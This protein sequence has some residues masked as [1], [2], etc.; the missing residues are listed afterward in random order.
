[1]CSGERVTGRPEKKG[2]EK[3]VRGQEPNVELRKEQTGKLFLGKGGEKIVWPS[4]EGSQTKK[5]HRRKRGLSLMQLPAEKGDW[6]RMTARNRR[7]ERF[8]KKKRKG[9][10]CNGGGHRP[11]FPPNGRRQGKNRVGRWG[12]PVSSL[13]V[14]SGGGGKITKREDLVL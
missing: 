2:G 5:G 6:K 9:K 8:E 14:S 7:E 13:L 11:F 3:E 4:E 10:A 12:V 1:M